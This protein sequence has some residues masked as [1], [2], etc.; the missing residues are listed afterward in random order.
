M[1]I[2]LIPIRP[3]L[4]DMTDAELNALIEATYKVEQ[5]AAGL[6]A[7]LDTTCVWELRR[8]VDY[9]HELQTFAQESRTVRALFDA[10]VAL[11]TGGGQKH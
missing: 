3:A 11:L 10:L 7:W 8:R 6:L 5:L 4:A 9:E 2:D 1:E